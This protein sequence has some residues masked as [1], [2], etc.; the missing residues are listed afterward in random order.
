MSLI[1]ELIEKLFYET[2]PSISIVTNFTQWLLA[3][4]VYAAIFW[5]VSELKYKKEMNRRDNRA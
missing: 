2:V 5:Y 4:L 1:M 3:G